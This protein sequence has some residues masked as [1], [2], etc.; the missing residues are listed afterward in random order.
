MYDITRMMETSDFSLEKIF[1]GYMLPEVEV[2][3][4]SFA[5]SI[6]A[7]SLLNE[8]KTSHYKAL[9]ERLTESSTNLDQALFIVPKQPDFR[10]EILSKMT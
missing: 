5:T 3:L 4:Q 1:E 2:Q 7:T 9:Q 6:C 10:K 8:E